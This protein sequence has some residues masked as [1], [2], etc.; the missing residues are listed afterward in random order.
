MDM[1]TSARAAMNR[2]RTR[3]KYAERRIIN[4][5]ERV[6]L[7]LEAIWER[8]V[9][10]HHPLPDW[11]I[12]QV[13]YRDVSHYDPIDADWR[14]ITVGEPWGGRD[15]SAFFRREVTMPEAMAGQPVT[16]RV[17]VGGDSLVRVNGV[18]H[19]GLDPFRN[20]FPLTDGAAAGEAFTVELE[21]YVFWYPAEGNDL[22]F[23]QADLVTIDHE[24]EAAYWD[25]VAAF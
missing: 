10:Q 8:T 16:M 1:N 9:T 25:F 12:K 14:P 7:R 23:Q 19:H 6:N 17:Y 18:A 21:S 11:H 20:S 3:Q 24:V 13:Y 15:V 2:W 22:T 4:F 5:E